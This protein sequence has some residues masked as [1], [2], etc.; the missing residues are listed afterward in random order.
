MKN[1]YISADFDLVIYSEIIEDEVKRVDRI[2][3]RCFKSIFRNIK[4]NN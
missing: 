4:L 1:K 2:K 3:G